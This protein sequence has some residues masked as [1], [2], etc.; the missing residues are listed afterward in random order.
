[1]RLQSIPC[2]S[3]FPLAL[4]KL[5]SRS[6]DPFWF[7]MG[8]TAT[9]P[10]LS[11][12]DTGNMIG[13]LNNTLYDIVSVNNGTGN[14]LVGAQSINVTCGSVQNPTAIGTPSNQPTMWNVS[15]YYANSDFS[16]N[17]SE[18]GTKAIFP[19]RHHVNCPLAAQCVVGSAAN[20]DFSADT[21]MGRSLI[22]YVMGPV[23]VTDSS[24]N[25]GSMVSL[26]PPMAQGMWTSLH[27]YTGTS[28][29]FMTMSLHHQLK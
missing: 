28:I 6:P 19:L 23:N 17:L 20:L 11:H 18:T 16:F 5:L 25:I 7:W 9:L 8:S 29:T 1:M 26:N 27:S 2:D 13:V 24:G 15:G 3:P 22:F 4:T 14:V 21:M 10:Y 12:A